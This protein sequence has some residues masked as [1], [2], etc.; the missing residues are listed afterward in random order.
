MWAYRRSGWLLVAI[1]VL[2]CAIGLVLSWDIVIAWNKAGWWHSIERAGVM[3]MDRFAA[4]WFQ[5]TGVS[6]MLLGWLTQQWLN[7]L[8]A[9]PP[10]LGG[11]LVA[12]GLLV[13]GVLPVSGAWL[14]V[15]LGLRMAWSP[16]S[17][18]HGVT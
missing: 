7:R 10:L 11:A 14:F 16:R 1:G 13:G 15:A 4:L 17:H 3:H 8:G 9:V 6:W 18:T 5:I 12:M 2:H